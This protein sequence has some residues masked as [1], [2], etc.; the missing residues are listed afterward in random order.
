MSINNTDVRLGEIH[1]QT[2]NYVLNEV[3]VEA[4][5]PEGA[6]IYRPTV[7]YGAEISWVGDDKLIPTYITDETNYKMSSFEGCW[8]WKSVDCDTIFTVE[9]VEVERVNSDMRSHPVESE[10]RKHPKK[11]TTDYLK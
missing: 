8:Q 6:I 4:K 3:N 1:L 11:I 2:D 5:I 9:L 10:K 7:I